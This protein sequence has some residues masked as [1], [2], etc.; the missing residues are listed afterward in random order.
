[1]IV[2]VG[3]DRL[4]GARRAAT[5][6]ADTVILDDGF[7]HR[8]LARDFDIVVLDGRAPFDAGSLLPKGR[9]RE[10]PRALRRAQAVVLTR[11]REDDPAEGAVE[12]VRGIGF[13]GVIARAGHRRTGFRDVQ[14]VLRPAPPRAYAF[15]GIGDPELFRADLEA[16]GAVI[17]GFRAFRDH[18]PYAAAEWDALTSQAHAMN[19]PLVT[20]E[21]DL[22]RLE[23]AAGV[24]LA[25]AELVVLR[26][27]TIVWDEKPLIDAVRGTLAA[28]TRNTSR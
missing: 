8:R 14:G 12:A 9:L 4:E 19:V 26:I 23:A 27:E 2:V 28:R 7:Q 5:A 15:C 13:T 1:V 20:T 10:R 16:E 24:S 3:A 25:R 11:L 6:G 17:V 18:H 22:S 21:K